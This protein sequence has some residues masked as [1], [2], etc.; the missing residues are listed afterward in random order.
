MP[1]EPLKLVAFVDAQN[2]YRRARAGFFRNTG[3]A[4]NGQISPMKLGKLIESR[5]GPDGSECILT[6][7]RVYTGRPDVSRVP[8]T[9]LAHRRQCARW[10]L[11]GATV[12]TRPLRYPPNWPAQRAEEKGIDVALSVDFVAMAVDGD[13]DLGVIMSTDTDM[14]PALEFVLRRY[15]GVRYIATAAWES[16]RN[17][18]RLVLP[19][20]NIWRY[21]LNR[22]DYD[23]VADPTNYNRRP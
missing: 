18:R 11:E 20:R 17:S 10:E 7:V 19:G 23:A 1:N 4:T 16:P 12:I 14:L 6:G 2:D 13:Y 9:Y 15:A 3:S 22:D 8:E 21:R 5:G